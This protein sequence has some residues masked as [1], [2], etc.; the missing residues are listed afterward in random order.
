[1]NDRI[2]TIALVDDDPRVLESLGELFES[3]GYVVRAY[4]SAKALIDAGLSNVDCLISDIGMPAVDG[5]ELHGLVKSVRPDLPVFLMTGR[6]VMGDQQRAVVRGVSGFF[7]KP[8]D[9]PALLA[10]IDNALRPH[11][12]NNAQF[13]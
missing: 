11:G 5:F 4:P 6:D 13:H 12:G 10:A 2:R 3:S 9:G 7:R 1:V 8:F